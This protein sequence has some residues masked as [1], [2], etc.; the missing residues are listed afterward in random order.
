MNKE[1]DTVMSEKK[2]AGAQPAEHQE[3]LIDQAVAE[4]FP[5]SDPISPAYEKSL[6]PVAWRND[7]AARWRAWLKTALPYIVAGA[8]GAALYAV[9]TAAMAP[10]PSRFNVLRDSIRDRVRR[11]TRH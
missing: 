4:T 3:S 11:L 6:A 7:D 5:A 10:P 8:A 1:H 2:A 9:V